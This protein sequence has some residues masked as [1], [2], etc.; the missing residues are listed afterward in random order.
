[1]R[2]ILQ[3][4][5]FIMFKL[6]KNIRLIHSIVSQFNMLNN[7]ISLRANLKHILPKE[8]NHIPQRKE[9][10]QIVLNHSDL[11]SDTSNFS[12]GNVK[13]NYRLIYW[14]Y[15]KLS[16]KNHLF[17]CLLDKSPQSCRPAKE[18]NWGQFDQHRLC[19]L[20]RDWWNML[21]G[22]QGTSQRLVGCAVQL[23][24]D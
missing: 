3:A 9:F 4:Y 14:A 11:Y 22:L 24:N 23:V 7:L 12:L 17:L 20:L 15:P 10:I 18:V 1:M 5:V 8:K 16:H 13:T 19:Q 2:Q 6:L 21:S